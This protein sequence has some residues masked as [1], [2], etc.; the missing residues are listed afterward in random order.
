AKMYLAKA[1]KKGATDEAAKAIESYFAGISEE[2]RQV[3]RA[4]LAAEPSHLEALVKFTERAYRR[5]ITS[6][7]RDDVR[8]FYRKLREKE[9]LN[10]EEALRDTIASVLLSPHF[11]FRLN[12][13]KSA[14]AVQPLSDYELANRLS[15]FLWSSMPD[16][17]L[18]ARAAA[19]DLHQPEVFKAQTQRMLRDPK[20]RGLAS[21]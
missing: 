12:L 9:E 6:T 15:Y 20:V 21:E 16:A 13:A 5:P 14:A 3:E 8:A 18:L 7:E 4:R 1:R 10:H 11:C 2:I 17:E 19:S